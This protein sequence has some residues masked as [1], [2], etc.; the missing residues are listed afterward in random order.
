MQ[1]Y[2]E[3]EQS[4]QREIQNVPCENRKTGRCDKG[5]TLSLIMK[6]FHTGPVM[7]TVF[8]KLDHIYTQIPHISFRN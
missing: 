3:K 7:S 4:G 1:I 2:N 5:Q 8:M 6:Q